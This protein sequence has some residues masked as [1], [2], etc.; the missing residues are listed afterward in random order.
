MSEDFAEAL[1]LR[2]VRQTLLARTRVELGAYLRR[3]AVL[4]HDRVAVVQ[5]HDILDFGHVVPESDGEANRRAANVFVLGDAETQDFLA[6]EARAPA[7][8]LEIADRFSQGLDA[9][10]S[11][12]QSDWLRA[13]LPAWMPPPSVSMRAPF[14]QERI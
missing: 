2:S 5:K 11:S 1:S 9:L 10:V 3:L 8:E 7:Y 13:A 12:R 14:E 4:L 6:F